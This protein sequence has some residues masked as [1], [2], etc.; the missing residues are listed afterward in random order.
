M[1]GQ[2]AA[3]AAA[4]LALTTLRQRLA[5]KGLKLRQPAILAVAPGERAPLIR[6]FAIKQAAE[7]ADTA[8]QF[9]GCDPPG[10][11]GAYRLGPARVG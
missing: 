5:R 7:L 2:R 8:G 9:A 11:A 1:A 3:L 4:R 10:N 6:M